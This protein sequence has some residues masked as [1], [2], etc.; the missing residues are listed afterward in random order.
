MPPTPVSRERATMQGGKMPEHNRGFKG[1]SRRDSLK[2]AAAAG[3]ATPSMAAIL[4]AC[5]NSSAAP[6][7]ST[8]AA[9]GLQLARPDNPITLPIT[10]DNPAIAD[11][12]PPEA[13]PLKIFG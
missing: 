1:L 11:G 2:R 4:A 6:G 9:G 8:S 12:L 10:A 7:G 3:I 13:G 5:A